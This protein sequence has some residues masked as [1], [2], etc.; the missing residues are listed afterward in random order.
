MNEEELREAF[1]AQAHESWS[2][3]M[4]YLFVE[5]QALTEGQ[6][7]IPSSL[8]KR[9]LQQMNT[10]YAELSDLE[11]ESDRIEGDA[12]LNI[13]D[14]SRNEEHADYVADAVEIR[15]RKERLEEGWFP[16]AETV[17]DSA[18]A[19]GNTHRERRNGLLILR[20]LMHIEALQEEA[21][22]IRKDI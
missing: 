2:G 17:A 8:V 16:L 18:I 14:P 6:V 19:F 3:W 12:Y 11:K 21:D 13:L 20:L 1:A 22:S 9:W 10:P 7:V 15:R 4:E 5:S